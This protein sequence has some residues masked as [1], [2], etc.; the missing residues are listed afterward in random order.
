MEENNQ[1]LPDP[2]HPD[3]YQYKLLYFNFDPAQGY[4]RQPRIHPETDRTI[5]NQ[6]W[7]AYDERL[8]IARQK[9]LAGEASPVY[10]H[11]E[12]M[13][14]DLPIL[15]QIAGISKWRI[16]RHFKPS[17]YKKLSQSTLDHYARVFN[18]TADQ[19]DNIK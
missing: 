19:L 7:D 2:Q 6:I 10:Y 18:L 12:R 4:S 3:F 8:E 16:K 13:K 17:K 15:S 1:P 5:L 14:M 9:Y 11:M